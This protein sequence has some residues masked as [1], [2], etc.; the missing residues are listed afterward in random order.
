MKSVQRLLMECS[1]VNVLVG[2]NSS[3]KTSIIQ[4]ILFVAQNRESP[5]GLNG[6]LITLGNLEENRCRF[7]REKYISTSLFLIE[8]DA[9]SIAANMLS[10]E[11]DTLNLHSR[12]E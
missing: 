2:T 5:C 3:G 9:E 6:K 4:S 10:R 12:Y 1:N 11:G 7:S 8:K